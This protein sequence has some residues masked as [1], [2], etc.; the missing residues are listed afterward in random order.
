M[1]PAEAPG[2]WLDFVAAA[3]DVVVPGSAWVS[4]V[5]A[6]SDDQRIE[7]ERVLDGM[8]R[9]RSLEISTRLPPT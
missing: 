1:D 7:V 2:E 9:E 8:L 5:G 4:E 3:I 6:L